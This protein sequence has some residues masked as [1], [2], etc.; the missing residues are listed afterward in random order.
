MLRNRK[1]NS[2]MRMSSRTTN[3]TPDLRTNMSRE[4][5]NNVLLAVV[6]ILACGAVVLYFWFPAN[7]P[8]PYWES[9]LNKMTQ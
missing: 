9:V 8:I 6:A 7:A 1:T 5:I 2:T 4:S 3:K